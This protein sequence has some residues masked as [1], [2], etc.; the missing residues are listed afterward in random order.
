MEETREIGQQNRRAPAPKDSRFTMSEP[1]KLRRTLEELRTQ[2][3][4]LAKRDPEVAAELELTISE[5]QAALGKPPLRQPQDTSLMERL[6]DA[7]KEY[8][9]THPAL[10]GN[11]GSIIDALGRMG[12]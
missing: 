2:L 5:A 3:D 11:L 7:V 8:E 12:I 4:E 1:D 9:A 6:T 10:A